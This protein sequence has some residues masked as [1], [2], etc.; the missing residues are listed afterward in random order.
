[1]SLAWLPIFFSFFE[2]EKPF[3]FV[4]EMGSE[5]ADQCLQFYGGA[6]YTEE[7]DV[8][9]AWRDSRLFRIGGGTT[10]T[11]RYYTAKLMGL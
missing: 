2:T 4:G 8:A 5:I 10:E 9:R 1:M 7:Y 6:G 11:L 3:V